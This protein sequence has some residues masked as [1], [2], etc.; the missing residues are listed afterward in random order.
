MRFETVY[1]ASFYVMLTLSTLTLSI[2]AQTDAPYA[3]IFPVAVAV[4]SLVAL[5]SVDR[6]PGGGLSSSIANVLAFLAMG[7]SYVEMRIDPNLLLLALTHWLVY[8]QLIKMFMTKTEQDDWF[9][10]AIGLLQVMVGAVISQSDQ[11]GLLLLLWAAS[12]I[13]V[14]ALFH[15][16]REA[17]RHQTNQVGP[18]GDK[19]LS[20]DAANQGYKGLFRFSF[21]SGM[22][23]VLLT[24]IALGGLIFMLMPRAEVMG[25][26]LKRAGV[27]RNLT[28]FDT[29]VRLGQLGEILENDSVVMTVE[30]YDEENER[31]DAP[32]D[33][34]WRGVTMGMYN[35]RNWRRQQFEIASYGVSV[36]PSAAD[37]P[38]VTQRI[39]LESNSSDVLFGLRPMLYA[40][41]NRRNTPELNSIDGS[42]RR[43][44]QP[45]QFDYEIRSSLDPNRPQPYENPPDQRR[46]MILRNIPKADLRETLQRIA[47]PV[48]RHIPANDPARR[49]EALESFLRDSGEFGY[50]LKQDVVDASIDPVED[51]LV[52][53]KAGHC[54]YFASALALL[55]RSI[56]IPSRVV[57]GYKGGD[58]NVAARVMHVRQKHAH[59]WVEALVGKRENGLPLWI[60]L[61]AT[62]SRQREAS[63]AK[64]GGLGGSL[65]QLNDFVRYVWVFYVVGFNAERQNRMIYQPALRLWND[66]KRGF[67]IIGE[68]LRAGWNWLTSPRDARSIFSWNGF[69]FTVTLLSLLSLTFWLGRK[70]VRAIWSRWRGPWRDDGQTLPGFL[71]YRRLIQ[72]LKRIGLERPPAETPREF[73]VRVSPNL[74]LRGGGAGRSPA[75]VTDAIPRQGSSTVGETTA[76]S[77]VPAAVT[78]AYYQLRFGR[79]AKLDDRISELDSRLDELEQQLLVR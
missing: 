12:A 29:E 67:R 56:E 69:A 45:G 15:L 54:E 10:F 9:L 25:R 78:E 73:A 60:T 7:L 13:W 17:I 19:T 11:L 62:P 77:A 74:L 30:F 27:S 39:R 61:D 59:S 1:R 66:A 32:A 75:T 28:G 33:P 50:S 52:N 46:L 41:G 76:L 35:G 26:I 55:L 44:P 31:A 70:L 51:F 37:K 71:L 68:Q 43:D 3:M 16:H 18:A 21:Y 47:E 57:N 36:R 64:V 23:R 14:L 58:W 24:S 2:D 65:R 48:V 20:R 42:L 72:I 34:Y 63:V 49:A 22:L 5:S 53:R 79:D 4:A 38:I 40:R 6:K 8:L